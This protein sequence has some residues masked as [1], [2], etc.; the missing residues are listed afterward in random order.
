MNEVSAA[1]RTVQTTL[2]AAIAALLVV[3]AVGSRFHAGATG[4]PQIAGSA[5]EIETAVFAVG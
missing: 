4:D 2:I 3:L 1:R 5:A